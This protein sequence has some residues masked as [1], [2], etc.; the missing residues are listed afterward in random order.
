MVRA[1]TEY[2]NDRNSNVFIAFLDATK[3]FDRVNHRKLFS[4]LIA[5]KV[6]ITFLKVIINWYCKLCVFVD[7]MVLVL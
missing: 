5:K 1:V 6:P 3:A 2:F 4:T 7:G